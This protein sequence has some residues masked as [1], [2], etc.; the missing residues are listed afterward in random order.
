M[1]KRKPERFA[2]VVQLLKS[3]P[4][5]TYAEIGRALGITRERVRQ[6]AVESGVEEQRQKTTYAL[7]Q[8]LVK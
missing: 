5:A 7:L 8:R 2:Q 1:T 4:S 6:I 3:A